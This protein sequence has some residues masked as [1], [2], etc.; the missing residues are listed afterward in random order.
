MDYLKRG[1]TAPDWFHDE[2]KA[3]R[4]QQARLQFTRSGLFHASDEKSDIEKKVQ[5]Y[6]LN[7]GRSHFESLMSETLMAMSSGGADF[8]NNSKQAQELVLKHLRRH[9]AI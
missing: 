7:E 3:E 1:C 4:D 2:R 6:V 5:R 9:V 8:A